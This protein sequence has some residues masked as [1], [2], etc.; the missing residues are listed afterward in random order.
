MRLNVRPIVLVC[1]PVLAAASLA[2]L[3]ASAAPEGAD[4]TWRMIM[5]LSDRVGILIDEPVR[6][7]Q[8][9]IVEMR[10]I[11]VY[12][13]DVLWEDK[14]VG[15]QEYSRVQINCAT[16]EIKLGPLSRHAPDGGVL[17]TSNEAE[18]V[19]IEP[20]TSS[21]E[22]AELRC[23]KDEVK[24]VRRYDDKPGWMEQ[25]REHLA[26]SADADA[27]TEGSDI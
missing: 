24:S 12:S 10:M 18:F 22:A 2:A 7:R 23:Q 1:A 8:G 16:W 14:A 27:E 15:W 21:A 13:P 6:P 4:V 19:A 9:D 5:Q 26:S 11:Y 20:E 25:V 17:Y 3:P